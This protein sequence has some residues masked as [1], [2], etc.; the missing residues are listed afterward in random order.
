MWRQFL[1]REDVLIVDCETSG[2]SSTDEIIELGIID[3]KGKVLLHEY[4]LPKCDID[5][6]A[7]QVHN[8]T[9]E[10]L[11]NKDAISYS[12]IHD[13]LSLLLKD[14]Q[15]I[16]AYNAQFDARMLRQTARMHDLKLVAPSAAGTRPWW[17]C[18]MLEYAS[19]AGVWSTYHNNYKWHKLTEAAHREGIEVEDAHNAIDD[20]QT[21]LALM[22]SV[23]G[24]EE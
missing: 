3:T 4:L 20:C 12:K 18:A 11:I 5:D 9:V 14:A 22:Q 1:N 21:T 16:I 13:G 24:Q 6:R 2:L 7:S 10:T 23:W 17:H 15:H 8:L 19:Y